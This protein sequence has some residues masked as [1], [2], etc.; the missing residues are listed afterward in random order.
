LT[1]ICVYG[2]GKKPHR[3]AYETGEYRNDKELGRE[4]LATGE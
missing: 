2:P 3:K 4:K 1:F